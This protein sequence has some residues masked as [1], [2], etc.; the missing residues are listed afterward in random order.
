LESSPSKQISLS[1]FEAA[2]VHSKLAA[3]LDMTV[4]NAIKPI[5][6][7]ILFMEFPLLARL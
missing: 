2:W 1:T 7:N 6:P 4:I 3:L 5:A